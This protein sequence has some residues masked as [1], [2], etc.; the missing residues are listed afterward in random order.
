MPWLSSFSL[1]SATDW[2]SGGSCAARRGSPLSA[3]TGNSR[4]YTRGTTN[5]APSE[6]KLEAKTVR[7][8][9]GVSARSAAHLAGAGVAFIIEGER[10]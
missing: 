10:R 4:G 2:G 6:R 7:V 5:A 9:A 8:S 3:C 1:S